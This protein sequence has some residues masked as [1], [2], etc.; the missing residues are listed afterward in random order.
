MYDSSRS[1]EIPKDLLEDTSGILVCDGYAGYNVVVNSYD[2]ERA[3]CLARARRKFVDLLGSDADLMAPI[4][5]EFKVIYG[6]ETEM[7]DEGL[8][9]SQDHLEAR[10]SKSL[11][12]LKQIKDLCED[13]PLELLPDSPVAKAMNYFLN[14]WP[15][16]KTL[17]FPSIT[18]SAKEH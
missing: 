15:H 11:E 1:G 9:G 18:I 3:G 16:L 13:R 10:Q 14:Q 5:D 7:A 2:R 17:E 4:L 8:L 6:V 12:A